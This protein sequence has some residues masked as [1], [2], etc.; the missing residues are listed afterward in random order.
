MI[1]HQYRTR[2]Q[3]VYR[4]ERGPARQMDYHHS[5]KCPISGCHRY[6]KSLKPHLIG[7]L[8][9][10]SNATEI[11]RLL[12]LSRESKDIMIEQHVQKTPQTIQ[13]MP[14]HSLDSGSSYNINYEEG[15]AAESIE[16]SVYSTSTGQDSPNLLDEANDCRE[17]CITNERTLEGMLGK[18]YQYLFSADSGSKDARSSKRPSYK[19]SSTA[20]MTKWTSCH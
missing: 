10:I 6:A 13:E 12:S 15:E 4:E 2:K 9:N 1:K 8:H 19:Q 5:K 20:L 18:Y 11:K 16:Y 14:L 3:Y 17:N 7:K